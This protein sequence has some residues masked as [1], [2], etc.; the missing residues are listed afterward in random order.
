[1]IYT[2]TLNPAIDLFI[3]TDQMISNQVNRTNSYDILANGKGVNVSFILKMLSV[4]NTAIGIGGG[5]TNQYI[6]Q[7]L[8]AKGIPNN[9]I[10]IDGITRIN[11]FTRVRNTN[12]EFKLV[13][14]GPQ[15]TSEKINLLLNQ[16]KQLTQNDILVISGSFTTGINPNILA[17]IAS[18]ANLI[19]FKLII[20]TSY[21]EVLDTLQYHP[22]LIKPN[23]EEIKH[24]FNLD[25][26]LTKK[27]LLYYSKKLIDL[28]AENVLLSLGGEGAL[29]VNQKEALFGT[30]PKG[31]VVNTACSGDTMLGTFLAGLITNK[32][33][34]DNLT[35]SIAA[36][37]STAFTS[38]LTDFKN[39]PD[40][41]NQV[42]IKK[43]F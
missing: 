8:S 34:E 32:K 30:A 24:W 38:G 12:E 4:T 3:D 13:N 15:V 36:G 23:E 1:M 29:F 33:I 19:G 2:C 6:E 26:K 42:T 14:R 39:V 28:G 18:I 27:E 31:E 40:L 41:M 10:H 7:T 9:F 17:E 35:Y 37:T 21:S 20:D 11:V 5:F 16:I 25:K 22:Y 43:I